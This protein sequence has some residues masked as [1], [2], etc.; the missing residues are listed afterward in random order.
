MSVLF[1]L[2]FN[3]LS[4]PSALLQ[5]ILFVSEFIIAMPAESYP[6]YS[7]FSKPLISNGNA[8]L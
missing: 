1:N 6:L 4:F 3:L 8:F 5:N 7:S 2:F